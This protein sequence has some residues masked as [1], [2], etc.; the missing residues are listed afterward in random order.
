MAVLL[1]AVFMC[2]QSRTARNSDLVK[3]KYVG[4]IN[5]GILAARHSDAEKMQLCTQMLISAASCQVNAVDSDQTTP[6]AMA[7][8]CGNASICESLVSLVVCRCCTKSISLTIHAV[9]VF[10]LLFI[11]LCLRCHPCKLT[12]WKHCSCINC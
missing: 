9:Y 2:T 5:V 7:A 12:D 10:L 11:A 3:C 4:N 6:L 1:W 8:M